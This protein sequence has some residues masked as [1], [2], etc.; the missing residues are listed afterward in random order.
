MRATVLRGWACARAEGRDLEPRR[1]FAFLRQAERSVV[2]VAI[3]GIYV[4]SPD[5]FEWRVL[6]P[7]GALRLIV[8]DRMPRRAIDQVLREGVLAARSEQNRDLPV[9]DS[10]PPFDRVVV[11]DGQVWLRQF[12]LPVDSAKHWNVYSENGA[13]RSIV[14]FPAAFDV[15]AVLGG[16]A[17]GTT[18]SEL[19]IQRIQVF[20]VGA[21]P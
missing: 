1:R 18:T 3:D 5:R 16:R 8:R 2:E 12:A 13:R 19:G 10:L 4:T 14:A 20:E 7:G 21:V 9:P 6:T 11:G 15:R 17:Y